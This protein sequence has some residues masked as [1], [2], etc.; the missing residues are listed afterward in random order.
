MSETSVK[1]KEDDFVFICGAS[2]SSTSVV[3]IPEGAK[4]E[5]G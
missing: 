3:K 2:V 1:W 5:I 4:P